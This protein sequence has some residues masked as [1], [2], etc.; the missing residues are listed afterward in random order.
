MSAAI[1]LSFFLS[2]VAP[3]A[4]PGLY[5]LERSQRQP[6]EGA[7][8][9][10]LRIYTRDLDIPIILRRIPGSVKAAAD[11]SLFAEGH[12]RSSAVLVLWFEPE[13]TALHI[14]H[15]AKGRESTLPFPPED[16]LSITVQT[17][18]LKVRGLVAES[19]T[20]QPSQDSPPDDS[21]ESPT[22]ATPPAAASV[23][24]EVVKS[25]PP[26][27]TKP[28]PQARGVEAGMAFFMGTTSSRSGF[29][30]GLAFGLGLVSL[31]WPIALEFEGVL[32]ERV[33][34][35]QGGYWIATRAL[36]FTLSLSF[37]SI[38]SPWTL[39]IGPRIG[40]HYQSTE[41]HSEDGRSGAAQSVS[42]VLGLGEQLRLAIWRGFSLTGMLGQTVL[43]PQ[44]RF[45]LDGQNRLQIGRFQ[46]SACLGVLYSL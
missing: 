31:T 1:I 44:Q 42:L 27:E 43:F 46:W 20:K 26:F 19:F 28:P 15:C 35:R 32:L 38:R 40:L 34:R 7:L 39:S 23:S 37:R 2:V 9:E 14:W 6:A 8:L 25:Q 18:A 45:A 5:F 22:T 21:R 24:S 11:Q 17:L 13:G 29:R 4:R 10:A 33:I 3:S 12:C 30:Q 36:P 41:G 16:E